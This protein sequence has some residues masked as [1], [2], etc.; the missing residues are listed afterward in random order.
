MHAFY[1]RVQKK[2]DA[3]RKTVEPG[4]LEVRYCPVY[5]NLTNFKVYNEMHGIYEGDR[6]LRKIEQL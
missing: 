6:M 2:V 3:L 4:T 5:L 1:Q